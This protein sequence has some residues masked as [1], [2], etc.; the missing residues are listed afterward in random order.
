MAR[1]SNEKAPAVAAGAS[2]CELGQDRYP[3]NSL[4]AFQAQWLATV[5]HLQPSTAAMIAAA[6]LGGGNG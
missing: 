4:A 3:F 6:A 5:F 2:T 1:P